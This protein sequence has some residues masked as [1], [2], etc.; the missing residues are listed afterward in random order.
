M[1]MASRQNDWAQAE[2]LVVQKEIE[3]HL[4]SPPPTVKG[5]RMLGD[6]RI[7]FISLVGCSS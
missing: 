5:E 1:A 6:K 7:R 2:G 4:T 3:S